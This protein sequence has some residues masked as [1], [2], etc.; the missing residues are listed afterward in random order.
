MPQH[1]RYRPIP[2]EAPREHLDDRATRLRRSLWRHLLVYPPLVTAICSLA[3]AS[4]DPSRRTHA[5]LAHMLDAARPKPPAA[6]CPPSREQLGAALVA[7]DESGA[8]LDAIVADLVSLD[9]GVVTGLNLPLA[10]PPR[11][12][13]GYHLYSARARTHYHA[14]WL[15]HDPG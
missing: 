8:L 9:A 13:R 2:A 11:S 14:L 6:P 7:A 5:A 15:A 12:T 10:A 4:L 3:R 1:D